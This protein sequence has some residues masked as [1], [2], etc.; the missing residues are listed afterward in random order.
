MFA[1]TRSVEAALYID[2]CCNVL[3]SM[4]MGLENDV[5]AIDRALYKSRRRRRRSRL[6][7]EQLALRPV[8]LSLTI[9]AT[10]LDDELLITNRLEPVA[11]PAPR[12]RPDDPPPH[13]DEA[14]RERPALALGR[15]HAVV[16]AH[17]EA[18][19]ADDGD[20]PRERRHE[21]TDE[22]GRK[23]VA[24]TGGDEEVE[25]VEMVLRMLNRLTEGVEALDRQ[26]FDQAGDEAEREGAEKPLVREP[27]RGL[28]VRTE[29]GGA[30]DVCER[31]AAIRVGQRA[32]IPTPTRSGA[33]TSSR[34]A[35]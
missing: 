7:V 29:D 14:A 13:T 3:Y 32:P 31:S 10:H 2:R 26:D 23:G 35:R 20:R 27:E 28:L 21:R 1:E 22:R 30:I 17:D 18:E 19:R 4:H 24:D 11:R 6:K 34:P 16:V 15:A 5:T 9:S 33:M 8:R 25:V 12:P